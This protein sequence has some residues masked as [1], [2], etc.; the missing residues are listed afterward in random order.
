MIVQ[1]GKVVAAWG[2]VNRRFKGHSVRKSLLNSLFGIAIADGSIDTNLTIGQIPITDRDTLSTLERSARI[3]HLLKAR[4]GVYHPAAAEMNWMKENRPKRD[5]H[6]PDSFWFYNNWDFNVLGTIYE[7]VVHTSIFKALYDK[8]AVPLQMEDYRIMDGVYYYEYEISDH[9]AYHLKMSTRDIARYGQLFLQRGRWNDKQILPEQWVKVSTYPHSKHGRGTKIGRWY[10][11]LWG[12]SEYFSRYG[13]YYAS[14]VGGQFLAVFPTEGLIL[15]NRT[16][17]YLNRQVLDREL[18]QLFDLIL[19]AKT[20]KPS[21]NPDL[22]ALESPPRVS[23]DAC[24]QQID[25]SRYVG[26]WTIEGRRVSIT[27]S[28]DD[29]L[30]RDFDLNFR[31]LPLSPGRFVLEDIERHLNVEFDVSGMPSRFYYDEHETE[32]N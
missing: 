20:G 1:S 4:S 18:T 27:K 8:I 13:M 19:A 28:N 24:S 23:T 26:T 22:I 6:P 32:S 21:P 2:D 31:L 29:L 11:Y 30:I 9:P 17:T 7:K 15:V 5:S 16:D 25:S 10:G 3:I 12:V 14:G